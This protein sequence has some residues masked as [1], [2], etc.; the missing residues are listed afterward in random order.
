MRIN[1]NIAALNTYNKLAANT[2]ATSKSLEKL[3]SGLKINKAGD[4]AAGLAIS[5]K[6]RGQ[7]SGLDTASNNANDGIS[8]IQTAEG[9]LSETHSILQRMRE[10]AVQSSNDTNT[11]SDRKEIQKEISQL[12][13]EVDRISTDTEF[14]TQKLL[15]GDKATKVN[16]NG[17]TGITNT[18][19]ISVDASVATGSYTATVSVQAATGSVSTDY[20]QKAHVISGTAASSVKMDAGAVS[21]S[22]TGTVVRKDTGVVGNSLTATSGNVDT[23]ASGLKLEAGTYTIVTKKTGAAGS[24]IAVFELQDSTGAKIG[25]GVASASGVVSSIKFKIGTTSGT[26]TATGATTL[27]G[28][29]SFT[30]SNAYKYSGGSVTANGATDSANK[31]TVS[32]SSTAKIGNTFKIGV[33]VGSATKPTEDITG[34]D[35]G[36]GTYSLTVTNYDKTAKTATLALQDSK[37]NAIKDSQGKAITYTGTVATGTK[38]NLAGVKLS[39]GAITGTS[40]TQFTITKAAVSSVKLT[41]SV[42]NSAVDGISFKLNEKAVDKDTFNVDVDSSNQMKFQI[43]ANQSQSTS[44]SVA[45]M[46]STDLGIDKLDLTTQSGADA[47]I[48]TIDSAITNVSSERAKL[49]AVQNRLEHTINNLSTSSENATSA[50]SRIRD[51][52]MAK[53]MTEFTKNNILSQAAQSMLAQANKQPQNVLSLLQ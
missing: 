25:S 23:M 44:L 13:S 20:T 26:L 5:E 3:S 49:G 16:T 33:D 22:H 17:Y 19:D 12:T 18:S 24:G 28:K 50:E 1:H 31:V 46:G 2:A 15:N 48:T 34:A 29:S 47:A 45:A 51:V 39:G 41:N 37:G 14:N 36:A 53:E 8:L 40:S 9:A 35:L 21:G 38:I 30:V 43:G 7:I 32:L 4:D 52:D 11:T 42:T 6:M 10:L 27:S